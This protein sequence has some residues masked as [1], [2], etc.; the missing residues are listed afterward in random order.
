MAKLTGIVRQIEK[1]KLLEAE[2]T[3]LEE[4][5]GWRMGSLQREIL[6][7]SLRAN[8][9]HAK[10]SS[11]ARKTRTQKLLRLGI[12]IEHSGL[13]NMQ[14]RVLEGA[15]VSA[16]ECQCNLKQ[17][18]AW[19]VRGAK[20]LEEMGVSGA[21]TGPANKAR[22]RRWITAG[23]VFERAGMMDWDVAIL[24][25]IL[26]V[27]DQSRDNVAARKRWISALPVEVRLDETAPLCLVFSKPIG[28][29][30][31][32]ELQLLGLSFDRKNKVWSGTAD[33]WDISVL[34]DRC[35]FRVVGSLRTDAQK[36]WMDIS[37]L[38]PAIG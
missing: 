35:W 6:Q 14:Y 33:S 38:A 20:I 11:L 34:T 4:K 27:I 25:S 21:G 19:R 7:R 26:K 13:S 10:A 36:A 23:A 22:N 5:N 16:R 37:S 15:L 3:T 32:R 24:A 2:I 31:S 30:L 29:D 18:E 1:I 28:D 17:M 12:L 9:E 8:R